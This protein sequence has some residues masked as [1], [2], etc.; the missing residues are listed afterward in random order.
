[1]DKV[2]K[3]YEKYK[4]RLDNE[5]TEVEKHYLKEITELKQLEDKK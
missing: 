4:K 1:M 2:H 3:E 5:L